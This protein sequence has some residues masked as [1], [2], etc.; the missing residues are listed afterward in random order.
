M[1]KLL[2]MGALLI[3]GATAFGA[4]SAEFSGN[5]GGNISQGSATANLRLA[6]RGTVIDTTN[7][8]VLVVTPTVN[9]G[10][11]GETLS[12]DFSSIVKN[13]EQ[14]Q[15]LEGKFTAEIW[16]NDKKVAFGNA[17]I[18]VS[19]AMVNGSVLDDDSIIRGIAL[20]DTV[21]AGTPGSS[22]EITGKEIGTLSYTLSGVQTND[23]TYTGTVNASVVAK[24]SGSFNDKSAM[25]T[26][27]VTDF[28]YTKGS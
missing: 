23:M 20:Y 3:V 17:E 14:P 11:D 16:A 12:F 27:A 1:K 4:V 5:T 19:L 6:S 7:K 21:T 25:V 15:T 9:A 28:S 18:D 10:A 24:E 2:F 13:A 8:A 26:V 22:G